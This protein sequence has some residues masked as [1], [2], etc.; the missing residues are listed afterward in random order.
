MFASRSKPK[1]GARRPEARRRVSP[2]IADLLEDRRLL[3]ALTVT[4]I[5]DDGSVGTL[6]WAIVQA[7]NGNGRDGSETVTFDATVF[8]TPKTITLTS[9]LPDLANTRGIETI[10]GP[11][12][13]VTVARDAGSAALFRIFAVDGGVT[14]KFSNLTMSGGLADS[15]GGVLNNGSLTLTNSRISGNSATFGGGIVN[16]GAAT[17]IGSTVSGNTATGGEG[18]SYY[19]TGSGGSGQGGAIFNAAS[20]SLTITNSTL[21]GNSAHGGEGDSYYGTGSGGSGQGG[22]IFNVASASLT[23]TNSTLSG[24]SASG[25]EGYSAYGN[26]IGGNGQGGAI[27]NGT[28]ASLIMT[29]STLSGDHATGGVGVSYSGNGFGGDGQGAAIFNATSDKLTVTDSTLSGNLGGEARE[30]VITARLT[31]GTAK[32]GPFLMPRR[33]CL[34]SLNRLSPATAP[35]L[36]VDQ[37]ALTARA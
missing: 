26:G 13:G 4:S 8:A 20:A 23:I 35:T 16:F 7:N 37:A 6:R 32:A 11:R 19:G 3:S 28:G 1:A 31:A 33:P 21:S 14:A 30:K 12:S 2:R 9:A 15:G 22:A 10:S 29:A 18:Y 25:G 36:S 27:F 24:D 17:I 34:S 5:A